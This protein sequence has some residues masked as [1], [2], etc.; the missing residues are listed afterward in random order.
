MFKNSYLKDI[1]KSWK[2]SVVRNISP[3]QTI[4][5]WL[6]VPSPSLKGGLAHNVV[7]GFHGKTCT[8][9][10]IWI[11]KGKRKSIRL[12]I[13]SFKLTVLLLFFLFHS[14]LVII[15]NDTVFVLGQKYVFKVIWPEPVK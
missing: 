2:K 12:R 13:K 3:Q 7:G 4:G 5:I 9:V 10:Q 8:S 1:Q 14:R 11:R 15:V 6:S